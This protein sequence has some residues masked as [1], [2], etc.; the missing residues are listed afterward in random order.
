M[1]RNQGLRHRGRPGR[2]NRQLIRA[3]WLLFIL[4]WGPG[5]W[6]KT[7]RP[8]QRSAGS[9]LQ[10]EAL[11][12]P[13]G[14]LQELGRAPVGPNCTTDTYWLVPEDR[15]ALHTKH[16]RWLWGPLGSGARSRAPGAAAG[17]WSEALNS[18]GEGNIL[19]DPSGRQRDTRD[20]P[21]GLVC[22]HVSTGCG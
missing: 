8:S 7:H 16:V 21:V 4:N 1:F 19:T 11:R 5:D 10:T 14:R 13:R 9:A 12:D 2:R 17:V 18:E 15:Q 6:E 22:A 3:Q 20:H